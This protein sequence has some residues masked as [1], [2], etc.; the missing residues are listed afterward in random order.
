MSKR[1]GGGVDTTVHTIQLDCVITLTAVQVKIG[2]K[3]KTGNPKA[4]NK[5]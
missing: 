4:Q 3:G 2:K 5:C 1:S